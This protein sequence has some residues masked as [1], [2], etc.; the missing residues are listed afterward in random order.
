MT[1]EAA[2]NYFNMKN[3]IV[4]GL[5]WSPIMGLLTTAIVAI[6]TRRDAKAKLNGEN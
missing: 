1:Q 6:F 5:V 2:E 3:Y 4:Q